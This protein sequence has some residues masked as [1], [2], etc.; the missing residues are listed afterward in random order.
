MKH[1]LVL[2]K[3]GQNH[4]CRHTFRVSQSIMNYICIQ[5]RSTF[6]CFEDVQI[7]KLSILE[8]GCFSE[9]YCLIFKLWAVD[10]VDKLDGCE[11]DAPSS[12]LHVIVFCVCF[13]E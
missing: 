12:E 3:V 10:K 9:T 8:R 6:Q 11:C 2:L 1:A 13:L 4:A 7:I 5:N